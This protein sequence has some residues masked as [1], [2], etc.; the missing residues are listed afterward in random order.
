MASNDDT[1]SGVG[2]QSW[3]SIGQ[4]AKRILEKQGAK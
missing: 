2:S 4:L 1:P 3:Q